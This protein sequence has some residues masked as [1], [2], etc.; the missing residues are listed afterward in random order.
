MLEQT[1]NLKNQVT[2]INDEMSNL[3]TNVQYLSG[4]CDQEQD[5]AAKLKLQQQLD[6]SMTVLL[7]LQSTSKKIME[8]LD[9][10]DLDGLELNN[11]EATTQSAI[12]KS[13]EKPELA[14]IENYDQSD[15]DFDPREYEALK[16]MSEMEQNL[17]EMRILKEI[18]D[19]EAEKTMLEKIL[20]HRQDQRDQLETSNPQESQ[21]LS[22]PPTK[23]H[24]SSPPPTQPSP[25]P[26]FISSPL[27]TQSQPPKNPPNQVQSQ[28]TANQQALTAK[29]SAMKAMQDQKLLMEAEMLRQEAEL[30]EIEDEETRLKELL[31]SQELTLKS[32]ETQKGSLINSIQD[33]CDIEAHQMRQIEEQ[34]KMLEMMMAE[35]EKLERALVLEEERLRREKGKGEMPRIDEGGAEDGD[36]DEDEDS[37]GEDF[38]EEYLDDEED[39]E[40]CGNIEEEERLV[41][42]VGGGKGEGLVGLK[43]EEKRLRDLIASKEREQKQIELELVV[44]EQE[45]LMAELDQVRLAKIE[46][47]K[48]EPAPK[49]TTPVKKASPVKTPKSPVKPKTK[50]PQ[51]EIRDPNFVLRNQTPQF[52]TTMSPTKPE[53]TKQTKSQTYEQSPMP[54]TEQD[55][56]DVLGTE[57]P[58]DMTPEMI[59][60]KIK[61]LEMMEQKQQLE[62]DLLVAQQE[63]LENDL[64]LQ[65]SQSKCDKIDKAHREEER[66]RTLDRL[67]AETDAKFAAWDS[68]I[69][70]SRIQ[71]SMQSTMD[72]FELRKAELAELTQLK[73]SQTDVYQRLEDKQ[74]EFS[75]L[76]AQR[77]QAPSQP[78]PTRNNFISKPDPKK[79]SQMDQEKQDTMKEIWRLENELKEKKEQQR[80]E[81][82]MTRQLE[83]LLKSEQ[84]A[85][86]MLLAQ[87]AE[88]EKI[89]GQEEGRLL[90]EQKELEKVEGKGEGKGK[91][92][93]ELEKD[94]AEDRWQMEETEREDLIKKIEAQMEMK[95]LSG[96]F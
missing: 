94:Q 56:L 21:N 90:A 67:M 58:E 7:A 26:E 51:H 39:E 28:M 8:K 14:D 55:L 47:Q 5:P 20:K 82:D 61:I 66:T 53:K 62:K 52:M 19:M 64:I 92:Q 41:R 70:Q 42:G 73:D 40:D 27:Q 76:L 93:S 1:T 18:K 13:P 22:K 31:E 17:E 44:Q 81:E 16:Q 35:K 38:E 2:M 83:E 77:P 6:D 63:K 57:N 68:K 71:E 33:D 24:Q 86:E 84:D 9:S 91:I 48:Q 78:P 65:E 4:K 74:A 75:A 29:L 89:A 32:K 59:E 54:F 87:Q 49:P 23:L 50:I 88:E 11:A 30:K 85:I 15:P 37:Y 45:E 69:D 10:F 80:Q 43:M 25:N 95:F 34:M 46:I 72:N 12:G 96:G 60:A 3:I 36:G 79:S